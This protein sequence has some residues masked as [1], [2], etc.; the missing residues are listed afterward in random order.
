MSEERRYPVD[1][2]FYPDV[3]WLTNFLMDTMV[4]LLTRRMNKSRSPIYRIL[5][6][7]AFGA[8]GSL[9]LFFMLSHFTV[10]Q[11]MVHFLLNPVMILIA[12]P[13][14]SP[15][16]FL[17]L[18]LTAYLMVLLLGGI[19]NWGTGSLGQWK[20]FWIWA[21]GGFGICILL[22]HRLE[23]KRL[24]ETDYE[25]L[26]LLSD[27]NLMLKGFLDTGNLLT[28]PMM[29][30]PVHII[31]EK[32]LSEEL[33]HG[34]LAVRY[35]PYHSLGQEHGLLPVVTL[36]AMYIKKTGEK[37]KIPPVYLEKPV[38]GI[39]KEKLFQGKSYQVILNAGAVSV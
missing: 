1:Y 10:Y 11:L 20:S 25:I 37:S 23:A 19:L 5:L 32:V 22:L 7:A 14:K 39:A 18:F 30:Q 2:V 33:L 8:A 9:L 13:V 12:F 17:Q 34:Q 27:R 3:F 29:H 21:V 31:Q 24:E 26:L 4:L 28:D 36:K 6:S 35:I 16:S 15:K 38:F